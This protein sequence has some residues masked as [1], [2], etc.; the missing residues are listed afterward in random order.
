MHA[1]TLGGG[2]IDYAPP[3]LFVS[4]RSSKFTLKH[5]SNGKKKENKEHEELKKG[6][7]QNRL[8]QKIQRIPWTTRTRCNV[9]GTL[10]GY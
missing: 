2:S 4:F 5:N 3:S 6:R 7:G 9:R 8:V 1:I 10:Y